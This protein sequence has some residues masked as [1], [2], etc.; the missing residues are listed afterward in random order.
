METSCSFVDTVGWIDL[1]GSLL[2]LKKIKVTVEEV[3]RFRDSMLLYQG[4]NRQ[5]TIV[6]ALASLL[7]YITNQ[8]TL[9]MC[10]HCIFRER[11]PAPKNETAEESSNDIERRISAVVAST[12]DSPKASQ[13]SG[14]GADNG[15]HSARNLVKSASISGSKCIGV[16]S[17]INI[18]VLEKS[19]TSFLL[20]KRF[21]STVTVIF[22]M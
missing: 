17:K 11:V 16:Q 13:Q 10:F 1:G 20:M 4:T 5:N 7:A 6:S 2:I 3:T 12:L 22:N 14:E 8:P 15:G 18:E 19:K 9:L 21:C